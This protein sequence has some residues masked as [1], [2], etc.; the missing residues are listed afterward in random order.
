[1]VIATNVPVPRSV[2]ERLRAHAGI[3]E[4]WALELE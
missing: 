4:A 1:M 3:L 2:V